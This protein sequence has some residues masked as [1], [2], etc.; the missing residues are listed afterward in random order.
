LLAWSSR[1]VIERAARH[2]RL[3]FFFHRYG[4]GGEALLMQKTRI[5]HG[6]VI[7]IFGFLSISMFGVIN[8]YSTFIKSLETYLNTSRTSISGAYSIELSCYAIFSLMMGWIV[9]K[10]GARLALWGAAILMGGGI[11]LCSTITE[12]WQLYLFFGVFAGI[13]HSAIFVVPSTI[14]SKWFIKKRG[15][16]MGLTVCGLG[17]GLFLVPPVSARIISTYGW[18]AS[19]LVLGAFA[20]LVLMIVGAFMKK[21]E[22]MGMQALGAGEE[23]K[24]ATPPTMR[25]YGLS[26]IL[27]ARAFWVVYLTAVFC[28]GA[29]QMLVVHLVPYC[30]SLGIGPAE[31]AFGLSCLGIGTIIGRIGMG[32][33]SDRIGRI[34]ALMISVG[35][36]TVTTFVMLLITNAS[37]LYPIMLLVG[38]GYGGWA[39]LAIVI[40]GDFFGVRNLGKATGVYFTNGVLGSLVGPLLAGW[41]FDVT[42]SYFWAII[43]AGA[44]CAIPFILAFTIRQ[45]AP[46]VAKPAAASS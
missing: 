40:L 32:W 30:S 29:E 12:V 9:D 17:F 39:V 11:A 19:F 45:Q 4:Y 28:Y 36:Q 6:W 38:F 5:F 2:P 22:E 43:F 23:A 37:L 20:F 8:S 26:E 25:E 10:Y 46:G 1:F 34:P 15:Q 33:I 42:R 41:I 7:V 31:A 16:A 24:L 35:L 13:G 44:T 14:V 27:K 3:L 21:P 18:R